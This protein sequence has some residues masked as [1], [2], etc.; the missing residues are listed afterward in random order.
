LHACGQQ[1]VLEEDV[2][3]QHCQIKLGAE[4]VPHGAILQQTWMVNDIQTGQ[5]RRVHNVVKRFFSNPF[6]VDQFQIL[7][8]KQEDRELCARR[9]FD[10]V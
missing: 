8:T 10:V 6:E 7:K 2:S 4:F 3:S 5:V 1:R 9:R